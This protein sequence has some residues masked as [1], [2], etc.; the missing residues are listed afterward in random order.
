MEDAMTAI[1]TVIAASLVSTLPIGAALAQT[2]QTS[3][4]GGALSAEKVANTTAVGQTKP[5][6][7]DASPTSVTPIERPTPRQVLDDAISTKICVGCSTE[8]APPDPLSLRIRPSVTP[9]RR[10]RPFDERGGQRDAGLTSVAP[11]QQSDLDTVALASAHRERADSVREK[12][13]GLWQSWLVSVCEGCGDQKPTRALSVE[14]WP[15][16]YGPATTGSIANKTVSV[17][18]RPDAKAAAPRPHASL[19]ADLSPDNIGSIRRMPQR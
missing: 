19:E 16:R 9:E 17:A 12:T 10:D 8:P 18:A 5:P 15:S 11:Q 6:S 1:R 4:G 14:D 3:T 13:A 2:D 7:R